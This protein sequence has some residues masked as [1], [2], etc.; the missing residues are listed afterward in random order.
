M[1]DTSTPKRFFDMSE[2][3]KKALI[4][5]VDDQAE[6]FLTACVQLAKFMQTEVET[7]L[8]IDLLKQATENMLNVYQFYEKNIDPISGKMPPDPDKPKGTT[9]SFRR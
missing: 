8:G 4:Q 1:S 2:A 6:S 9:N 7:S 5:A 3:E